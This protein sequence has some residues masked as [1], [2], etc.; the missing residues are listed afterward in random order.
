MNNQLHFAFFKREKYFHIVWIFFILLTSNLYAQRGYYDAP[1]KRYEANAG[2]LSNGALTTSKSYIQA[3]LQSEATDQQCVNMSATNATVQWTLT[4]AADGLV[5]R[6]SVPDGQSATLGVYN[7]NT[8]ITT[9]TLTSTW[10]WEYL[11]SNGNPNNNGITNQNPRMRFDE[12]RYKLPAKISA[13]GTLKLVRESGNV[14]VDFAEMEPVPTA[15]TAPTGSVTYTGNGSDLQ[16]FIDANGGKKIFVPGGVYNVNRE[17]YFGVAN[18]SL[19]GAGMWYT[20]INFTNTSSLNGGL[21][22][23]AA[24]ISFTDLYLTTNSASRSNSYKAI[25][26]VFTSTSIVKNIWAEHFECGAWIAQY[27]TGGPAIADGFT[28][29]HCRF[30]NNYADGINLC[31][32]TANAIVEHCSFRNNGDDD[33]AIWSADGLEC[34]NNT[35]R[36]N[37]SENCW[38]ACGLAIYGGKNNKAYNLIIKDN[39]EAGIRVS[40]NFP[41]APFNN[42]GM[43]EI[44]DITVSTCGTFNDTYNNPVAAVDIFSATNAGTQVKNVQLYNIDILDSRNDA[45]SISKRSGDGIYNLSFKDITVNG[46]GKEFPN[47]NALNRNWGRGYFVLIAGSPAG[48]GTYCNMNYSN[49]GG[50]AT[51]D[52][53]LSAIG[54]F[55]WTQST[56]CSGT[57][58]IAVTGVSVAPSTA[59]LG[60]GAT[61]QLT[62]TVAPANATNKTVTYSS[63]NTGV[64]TVN[65][66]GLVTAI[67]AGSA[68]ITV[69]T[70]DGA[71]IATSAITVTSSNVAVTSV[72]LSPASASLSVGSTQQLTPTILPSNATNK[73]VSYASNNT[74]VATVNASGLVTAIS[75]G[76]ATITVT[77]AD[78]NKTSTAII[79][80]STATGNYFTIKN[81]WTNNY[82]Y[83]AG[84]NV[85]Y[86][87]TVANNN[88]KWEKVA[89]DATYFVLKNVG[90]GDVMHIENLTGAVQCTAAGSDWW[91]AQW[92]SE[93]VDGTFVRIKNRWQT[94]SMIHI[95]NL[96]GSAQYAGGQNNW[97][98]AQWQFQ[99]TSTAKKINDA[100]ITVEDNLISIYPNPSVNKEFN[101]VLPELK[102][103]DTAT[104]TVTDIN[105]R[106]VL[107]NQLNTS[108]KINHNLASGIYVVTINSNDFNVSKKLI[109][110]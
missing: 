3:D 7:G 13:S 106:K 5:I 96:N 95:E 2:Q 63:N 65:G 73:S 68:T 15:L 108:A 55:S 70:Q 27:N 20:Q 4:E 44:H 33:Q 107:I 47:N 60:I 92:S 1:Y 105:G 82:L 51:T 87:A 41:G 77:T 90:T 21:R 17:L 75:N 46:T 61:Q 42:D 34:I 19:I 97:E 84:A 67:A 81:R 22:A 80:V 74:G 103:G 18:T 49:R 16:T 101:I 57:P 23:N 62:P 93:N 89:V 12:V 79:T 26:G 86:G 88:Y 48:N 104:L 72:S 54:T 53:E 110:K 100:E 37:T 8:K 11:W 83:D 32:G 29:S 56:S 59:S 25:N 69:T 14:H 94:G 109:V 6:Y 24:G 66:S 99:S 78:G 36:Y 9:L 39:L 40:N 98:S 45:I 35:F 30:R 64:A 10:S 85:G 43:H 38:R 91:S 76:T 50:S 102:A 31:K 52:Q 71:K 28:V 58:I